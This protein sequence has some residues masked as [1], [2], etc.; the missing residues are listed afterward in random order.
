MAEARLLMAVTSGPVA[1][2]GEEAAEKVTDEVNTAEPTEYIAA[3][4]AAIK[5]IIAVDDPNTVLVATTETENPIETP[6]EGEEPMQTEA[7]TEAERPTETEES[8]GTE[9][10]NEC[11]RKDIGC[12]T[13]QG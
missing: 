12:C 1:A 7:P 6:I 5:A 2:T 9:A 10:N 4:E 3:I 13:G 11:Y 8:M